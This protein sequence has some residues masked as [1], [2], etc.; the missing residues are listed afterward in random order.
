[1]SESP[2]IRSLF[3]IVFLLRLISYAGLLVS[4]FGLWSLSVSLDPDGGL[5][6]ALFPIFY[7]EPHFPIL[8]NSMPLPVV[9]FFGPVLPEYLVCSSPSFLSWSPPK[10]S[11]L[12]QS[13]R[14]R[15]SKPTANVNPCPRLPHVTL[16][17]AR[18]GHFLGHISVGSDAGNTSR[19][20]RV[21]AMDSFQ[22]ARLSLVQ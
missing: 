1:M 8:N 3:D 18:F 2:G 17:L 22:F 6:L 20:V 16:P 12:S 13:S 21:L 10:G 5:H 14:S 11:T 7:L 9:L 19:S 4:I 15:T